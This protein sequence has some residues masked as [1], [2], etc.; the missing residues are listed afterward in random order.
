MRL[1]LVRFTVRWLITA[2]A[3][4]AIL[5]SL[6][7][8]RTRFLWGVWPSSSSSPLVPLRAGAGLKPRTG[9]WCF[10]RHCV[11]SI[12]TSSGWAV[13]C[14]LGHRP[15]PL[16]YPKITRYT[17]IFLDVPYFNALL[18]VFYLPIFA[19]LGWAF[20]ASCFPRPSVLKP[21]RVLPVA[22]LTTLV[23][24]KWDPFKILNWFWD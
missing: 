23:A 10:T 19:V 11:W 1:P 4:V 22:W 8:R 20:A 18:S 15:L 17:Q 12:C 13:W 16:D 5:L 21:L 2:V 9:R 3:F 7:R 14:F 6:P 24:V